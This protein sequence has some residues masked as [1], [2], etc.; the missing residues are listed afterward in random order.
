M[1]KNT[2]HSEK[3]KKLISNALIGIKRT[4]TKEHR[5]KL[6]K[7]RKGI[8]T[9][10]RHPAWKGENASYRAIH[11][12]I[13]RKFGK[14]ITCENCGKTN[15]FGQKIHWANIGHRY[16]RKREFWKRFCAKCHAAHDKK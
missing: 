2:H 8:Y 12:W 7:A 15:L 1:N 6:S 4:F 10:E 16:E 14:P 9:D 11:Q 3:T 13:V 5:E